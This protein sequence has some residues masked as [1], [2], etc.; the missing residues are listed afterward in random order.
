MT[1]S[2]ILTPLFFYL[3]IGAYIAFLINSAW[4]F[5][6]Y[7]APGRLLR[8]ANLTL[9]PIGVLLAALGVAAASVNA[10]TGRQGAPTTGWAVV[11]VAF[12]LGAT[13]LL[14]AAEGLALR[15]R[16]DRERR[17]AL[18][19]RSLSLVATAVPLAALGALFVAFATCHLACL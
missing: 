18:G 7:P 9:V 5:S 10:F 1:L 6:H 2:A 11:M 8:G 14:L 4:M 13:S 17:L 12:G 19:R 3:V 15:S 16:A